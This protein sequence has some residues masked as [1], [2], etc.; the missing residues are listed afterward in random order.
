MNAHSPSTAIRMRPASSKPRMRR[1]SGPASAAASSAQ[2]VVVSRTVAVVVRARRARSSG[3]VWKW[4]RTNASP[5]PKRSR[6]EARMMNVSSVSATP[7]SERVSA[8]V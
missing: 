1:L 4:K 7:K 5:R 6:I 2:T 8:R 3:G